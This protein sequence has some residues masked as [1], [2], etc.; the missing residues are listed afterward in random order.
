MEAI[1]AIEI[2]I[3]LKEVKP[4][5]SRKLIVPS[6]IRYDQ[7]H[8]LIQL[9]FGWMNYHLYSFRLAHRPN[10]E[11]SAYNNDM[12]YFAKRIPADQA[13]VYPD[14]QH[15]KVIY[16]Y[17]FGADWQ[18]EITLKRTLTFDDVTTIQVPSCNWSRGAN[19]AEDGGSAKLALPFDRR[20]L[21]A[22]L[23]LWSQAGEQLI[24]ADD[25]GLMPKPN[26]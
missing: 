22:R 23:A 2:M 4:A 11:Y 8:V 17:D 13:Y 14:L 20:E 26:L 15:D 9:T 10:L 6:T 25:L 5:V 3:K 16:T 7:L 12:T 1:A 19:C 18:H 21:N 24:C